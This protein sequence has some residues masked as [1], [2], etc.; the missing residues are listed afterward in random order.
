MTLEQRLAKEKDSTLINIQEELLSGLVPATGYARSYCRKINNL[1]D[2]GQMCINP[3]T[4]RH[5]YLPTLHNYV[6]RELSARYVAAIN[7]GRLPAE[8]TSPSSHKVSS[9]AGGH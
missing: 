3:S 8:W 5:L 4:Y 9:E 1:I 6:S 2:K 7:R